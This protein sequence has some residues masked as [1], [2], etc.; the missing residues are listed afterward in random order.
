MN[1]RQIKSS[2]K[3]KIWYGLLITFLI[4]VLFTALLSYLFIKDLKIKGVGDTSISKNISGNDSNSKDSTKK[5]SK[6]YLKAVVPENDSN[7]RVI[8]YSDYE[9]YLKS[10]Q[11]DDAAG[12]NFKKVYNGRRIN[13]AVTGVD[14]RLGTN[15][16]HADANHVISILLDSGKIEI[17]SVPRDTPADAGYGEDDTTG[18]NKLTIV[19]AGKGLKSYHKELARIAGLDKIHYY[20]EFGF[21]QALGLIELLGYKNSVQTLKVLR[22]RTGLGGDDFQRVYNQAQFIKQ[23]LVANFNT[24]N[25]L[26]GDL[27]I[28][29]GLAMVDTDLSPDKLFYL[30][31]ELKKKGFGNNSNDV[32]VKIR[33]PMPIKFKIYDLDKPEVILAL[34]S[35]IDAFNKTQKHDSDKNN[36]NIDINSSVVNQLSK[37]IKNSKN[38]KQ[39]AN[40]IRNMTTL[41]SQRAWLQISNLHLR[42]SIRTEFCNTLA[43][44]Y[45]RKKDSI[46]ANKVLNYL[47]IEKKAFNERKQ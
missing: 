38:D 10:V 22:S 43:G 14:S 24:F 39:T 26:M 34:S 4:L 9:S 2:G 47:E 46:S 20:I 6:D 5:Y 30:R 31:D 41:Y 40:G 12:L 33:P 23:N 44:L 1:D 32:T 42:D 11:Y 3:K 19:R 25:S 35:K 8:K 13:I 16:K 45:F 37:I 27:V 15:T 36:L 28:R 18:Q 21:S 7:E 17:I 29:A